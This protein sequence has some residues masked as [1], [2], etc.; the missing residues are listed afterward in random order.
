MKSLKAVAAGCLFIIITSLLMQLIFIF[1]AVGYNAIARDYPFLHDISGSFR[2]FIGIP[3]FLLIMFC[4]G[5]ITAYIAN[6]KV[7]FH[8]A[9]VGIITAGG[10]MFSALEN[11]NLTLTGIIVLIL[12]LGATAAGGLYWQ[13][14]NKM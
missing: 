14:D 12:A 4:G 7:L 1:I 11:S 6:T 9:A 8:C 13:R 3:V 5:Y 10:M 2:Y